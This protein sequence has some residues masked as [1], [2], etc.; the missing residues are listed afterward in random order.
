MYSVI[1]NSAFCIATGHRRRK[2]PPGWGIPT[3]KL[4][5]L[6]GTCGST[7]SDTMREKTLETRHGENTLGVQRVKA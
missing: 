3:L 4:V 6:V 1:S 7:Y 5:L 2:I